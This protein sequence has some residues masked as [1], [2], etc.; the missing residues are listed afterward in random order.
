MTPRLGVK[1]EY[2]MIEEGEV[3]TRIG[4]L[5]RENRIMKGTLV[6]AVLFAAAL[7]LCGA[8]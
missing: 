5:E 1:G 4:R 3:L 6:A 8:L 2:T 7:F